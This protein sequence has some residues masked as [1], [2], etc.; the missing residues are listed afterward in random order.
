MI[1]VIIPAHNEEAVIGRCLEALTGGA[2]DGELEVIVVCNGCTDRTAAVAREYRACVQVIETDVACKIP[3][4]NLGDE[5]ARGF[6]RFFVDADV[7]LPLGSLRKLARGLEEGPALAIAPRAE[8]D[9]RGC[10]WGVR[11]YYA[12]NDRLPTSREGIGGSGVYGLSEAGRRRFDRFPDLTADDGFVRLQFAPS[13]RETLQDCRSI[14]FAPKTVKDLIA[15]MTRAHYGTCELRE[16]LPGA[17][18]NLGPK[19]KSELRRL[20]LRFWLWPQLLIYAY[21]KVMARIRSRQRIKARGTGW[22]RD[23]TSRRTPSAASAKV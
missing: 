21:V 4:L 11:A 14:V 20:C 1:S 23:Q 5:A 2:E 3:A 8:F 7:V 6:P 16:K 19:N 12:I 15:I 10:S 18:G 9:L 17:W 22:E 13:E